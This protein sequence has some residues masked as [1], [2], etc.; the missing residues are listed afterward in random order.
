ML[1]YELLFGE[2]LKPHGPAE[3]AVL[4]ARDQLQAAFAEMRLKPDVDCAL[5]RKAHEHPRSVRVN[6]LKMSVAEAIGHFQAQ[7][8]ASGH[9]A[10]PVRLCLA[11]PHES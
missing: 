2:G 1:C 8:E 4:G 7:G 5:N 11:K 10:Q 3:R 9:S 6:T